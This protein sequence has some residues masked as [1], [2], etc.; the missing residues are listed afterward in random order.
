MP[1]GIMENE[2]LWPNFHCAI[3]VFKRFMMRFTSFK[4]SLFSMSDYFIA[5]V[6]QRVEFKNKLFIF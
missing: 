1:A 4:V 6:R 5:Q 2:S 3:S